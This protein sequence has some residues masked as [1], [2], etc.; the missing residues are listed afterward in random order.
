MLAKLRDDFEHALQVRFFLGNSP[1]RKQHPAVQSVRDYALPY[2]FCSAYLTFRLSPYMLYSSF[3]VSAFEVPIIHDPLY[4]QHS[5]CYLRPASYER[6]SRQISLDFRILDSSTRNL[7]SHWNVVSHVMSGLLWLSIY[8]LYHPKHTHV[9]HSSCPS[10][11]E[12]L[13]L[14]GRLSVR[15]ISATRSLESSESQPSFK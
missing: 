9:T 3:F 10:E 6:N 1:F 4:R 11:I 5:V 8:A 12:S 15:H 14:S 7:R 2:R 13:T